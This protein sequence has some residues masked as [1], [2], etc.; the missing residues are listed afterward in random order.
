MLGAF[1]GGPALRAHL[2]GQLADPGEFGLGGGAAF[3]D[4]LLLVGAPR[5]DL[6]V[7]VAQRLGRLLAGLGERLVALGPQAGRALLARADDRR[8]LLLGQGQD[9]VDHRT[10]VAER[11]LLQLD[12]RPRPQFGQLSVYLVE[13]HGD[14]VSL[15]QRPVAFAT[16]PSQLDMGTRDVVVDLPLV[17]AAQG[18]F[19]TGVGHASS[20]IRS[21]ARRRPSLPQDAPGHATAAR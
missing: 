20:S 8:G 12:G 15:G 11:R 7:E 9:L 21:P 3:L 14:L 18:W 19:E 6:R 17:V 1:V 16:E 2:V 5:S 13:L 10:Q 4:G